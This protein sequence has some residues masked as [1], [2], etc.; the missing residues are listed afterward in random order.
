MALSYRNVGIGD[1]NARMSVRPDGR[2]S[3]L[4]TYADTGTGAHTIL[5]QMI[6]EVLEIPF[7]QVGLEVGTTDA[8]R[9]ESG[10]G[11]S[12]VTFVLGQAVLNAADKLKALLCERAAAMLGVSGD[13]VILKN[14]RLRVDRIALVAFARRSWPKPRPARDQLEVESYHGALKPRPKEC[15]LPAWPKSTSTWRPVKYPCAS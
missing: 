3:L 13:Q 10:T 15:S 1:A 9:S 5:C 11:A 12:R 2:I 8:F 4:T 14:G 7:S 6:A